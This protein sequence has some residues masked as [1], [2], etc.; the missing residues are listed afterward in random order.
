M[1]LN[2][3]PLPVIDIHGLK[4]GDEKA[5]QALG[6]TLENIQQYLARTREVIFDSSA[7]DSLGAQLSS[8]QGRPK[9]IY[10]FTIG[11]PATPTPGDPPLGS[12]DA[13]ADSTLAEVRV[14]FR[15]PPQGPVV[16][17]LSIDSIQ[18]AVVTLNTGESAVTLETFADPK[19]LKNQQISVRVIS[20]PANNA[21]EDCVVQ[22]RCF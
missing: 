12:L 21:G 5:W 9:D 3:T 10:V 14:R 8:L 4:S 13:V 22:V 6:T 1:A 11:V 17:G 20:A 18:R 7:T 16:F 15:V 2:P 19:V